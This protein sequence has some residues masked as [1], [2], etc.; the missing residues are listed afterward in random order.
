MMFGECMKW[1]H[2]FIHMQ[3]YASHLFECQI[4]FLGR[5]SLASLP[6]RCT[7][8]QASPDYAIRQSGNRFTCAIV[9][10]VTVSWTTKGEGPRSWGARTSKV[11]GQ[12][13]HLS[14]L[15]REKRN[16]RERIRDGHGSSYTDGVEEIPPK[17]G[18]TE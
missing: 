9:T 16:R 15:W 2:T 18:E 1:L 8:T 7:H 10:I 13:S 5:H 6:L 11:R 14:S 17:I 4:R 3:N 12:F